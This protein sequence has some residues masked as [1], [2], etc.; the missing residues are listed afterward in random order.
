MWL[1][2]ADV[3]KTVLHGLFR[4]MDTKINYP[5]WHDKKKSFNTWGSF[6][7]LICFKIMGAGNTKSTHFVCVCIIL[8]SVLSIWKK[9]SNMCWENIQVQCKIPHYVFTVTYPSKKNKY[10]VGYALTKIIKGITS[11]IDLNLILSVMSHF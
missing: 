9:I 4:E 11:K 2:I 10:T 3:I 7:K 6:N 8:G 5:W 1:L